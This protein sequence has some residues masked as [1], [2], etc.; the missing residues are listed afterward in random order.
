MDRCNVCENPLGSPV[1]VSPQGLSITSLTEVRDGRT[2]VFLCKRCGHLQTTALDDI[3]EYYESQYRILLD[4]E[5]EDQLY[6]VDNGRKIFR[7]QHQVDTLL[8]KVDLASGARVLD[9]GCA[10]GATARRLGEIRPDVEIC[11]FDVSSSYVPFWK[12]FASAD[13]WAVH[14]LPDDW[15][16]SFDLVMSFFVIE[17]VVDPAD[18]LDRMARLLKPGG[19]IYFIIPNVYTNTADFVVADHVNHFSERSL[20]TVLE[21]AGL[22]PGEID[23]GSH[24][25]AW[26]V[27]AARAP[28]AG[29][30]VADR[31]L[32]SSCDTVLEIAAFWS[33]LAGRVQAFE[34]RRAGPGPAAIYGAGFYGTF[35]ASCLDHPDR[36]ECFLDQNPF[37]QGRTIMG[38]PIMA[39]D[40]LPASVF[41][42]YVGLNPVWA[43]SIIDGIESWRGREHEYLFL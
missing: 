15:A 40:R 31:A 3:D 2:E 25:G 9:Y 13:R 42:I 21:R 24:D 37:R 20:G 6:K 5:E 14:E 29:R 12:R 33:E 41:A 43:R 34:G 4:S 28:Q 30:L 11:L 36:V 39:P 35:I 27:K 18:A 32:A 16:G 26:V 17:H 38:R 23:A 22:C 19:V 7:V 1:Y 10:K 8:G